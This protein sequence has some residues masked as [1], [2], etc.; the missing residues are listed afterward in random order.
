MPPAS[1]N[2]TGELRP[3][4]DDPSPAC[5]RA[6]LDRRGDTTASWTARQLAPCTVHRL[7]IRLERHLAASVDY[8]AGGWPRARYAAVPNAHHSRS[9]RGSRVICQRAPPL[10]AQRD[11]APRADLAHPVPDGHRTAHV[12]VR[13]LTRRSAPGATRARE[14]YSALV[15]VHGYAR[16]L[17]SCLALG[18]ADATRPPRRLG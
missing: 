3:L 17:T 10:C 11:I 6:R 14:I 4:I 1:R 8:P 2:R 12:H 16:A 7:P 15:T 5:E 18:R 13:A 9:S